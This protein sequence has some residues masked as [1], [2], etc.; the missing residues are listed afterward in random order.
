[1]NYDIFL[2]VDFVTLVPSILTV[3]ACPWL[4]FKYLQHGWK[5]VG[6]SMILLLTLSDFIYS[7]TVL[8]TLFFPLTSLSTYYRFSFYFCSN[9]SIYWAASIAFLVYKTL[10]SK[11]SLNLNKLFIQTLLIVLAV[12]LTFALIIY[13]STM[14]DIKLVIPIFASLSG[15]V[16]FAVVFYVK[17]IKILRAQSEYEQA[18]TTLYIKNLKYYCFAQFILYVPAMVYLW[19][20]SGLLE[21]LGRFH[22]TLTNYA[23]GLASLAGFVNAII[24]LKQGNIK[25]YKDPAKDQLYADVTQD[26]SVSILS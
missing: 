14:K 7:L 17:S 5:R 11:D 15:A 23:E 20:M 4:F 26:L 18:S 2:P 19:G 9:F 21:R 25:E 16:I 24:F 3:L 13:P 1:M 8:A 22:F 6:F 12:T 10:I